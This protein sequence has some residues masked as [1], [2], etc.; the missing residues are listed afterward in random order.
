VLVNGES[1]TSITALDRG[2]HYGDGLFETIAV[3][4]GRPCLWQR[5]MQRLSSGCERLGIPFPGKDLLYAEAVRE[6]SNREQG[7]LKII[8]TRGEGGQ[9]YQPPR[10]PHPSRILNCGTWPDY[11]EQARERGVTARICSTRLD[12]CPETAGIKHLNRLQQVLASREWDDPAIAEGLMLDT[13]DH[14]IEGTKSNLFLI[15]KGVLFTPDLQQCGVAGVMRGLV[16]DIAEELGIQM[17]MTN[18]ELPDIWDSEGLFLTNSLIGIWPV[19]EIDGKAFAVD[20]IDAGLKQKVLQLAF[21]P[22]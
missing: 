16:I 8:I 21:T 5:H 22:E 19:R 4:D 12:H 15:K 20:A 3:V 1:S 18:L 10:E 9:G 2:L 13:G 7:V 14:L 6:I 11:P 17:Q